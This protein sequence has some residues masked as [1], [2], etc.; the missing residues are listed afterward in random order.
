MLVL[1]SAGG[2]G[3]AAVEVAT[4]MGAR[5]IAGASSPQKCAI[6][7]EMGAAEV[8]DYSSENLRDRVMELQRRWVGQIARAVST[9]CRAA[10]SSTS[11]R[12]TW[13]SAFAI[14]CAIS[15][16]SSPHPRR[17]L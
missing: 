6:A 8:I 16:P 12:R 9:P 4:A 14:T 10:R 11:M 15:P 7:R 2:C 5:V 1:G 3:S 13:M 17:L